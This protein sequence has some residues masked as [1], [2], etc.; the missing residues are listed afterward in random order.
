MIVIGM[1]TPTGVASF[2]WFAYQPLTD[3]TFSPG[4][5]AVILSRIAVAGWVIFALAL[6][7]LAFLAGRV[8]GRRPR[9]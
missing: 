7:A 5:S 6:V 4:G 2:G 1:F 8:V 9:E 3:A